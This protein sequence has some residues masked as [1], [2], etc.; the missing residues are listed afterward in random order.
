VVAASTNSGIT[1]VFLEPS[2]NLATASPAVSDLEP[3]LA[4][5]ATVVADT[6]GCSQEKYG[7]G[8]EVA[9]SEQSGGGTREFAL[10][11]SIGVP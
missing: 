11:F 9:A 10:K 7:E 8:I 3:I 1:C 5:A 2:I 4:P 6:K